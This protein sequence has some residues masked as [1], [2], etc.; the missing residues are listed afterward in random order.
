MTW[1]SRHLLALTTVA[2]ALAVTGVVFG[3]GRPGY[4]K[5]IP[6]FKDVPL[7]YSKVLFSATDARRVFA[8]EGI[9]LTPRFA[10]ANITT[11]GNRRDVLEVDIFGDPETLNAGGTY[12]R[13]PRSCTDS[14]RTAARWRG[15]VRVVAN[16]TVDGNGAS[17]MH[18]AQRALNRL[19]LP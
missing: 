3:F 13:F 10:S 17:W 7:P 8:A 11:L 19:A 12:A 14:S 16:C 9:T 1:F 18:R 2:V 4:E 6:V 5:Q 15:N